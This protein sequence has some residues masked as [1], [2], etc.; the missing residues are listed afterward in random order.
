VLGY[1][2]IYIKNMENTR[3]LNDLIRQKESQ[4]SHLRELQQEITGNAA[5]DDSTN[6]RP[7][8]DS[9]VRG[10]E[11]T[12][13]EIKTEISN[14]QDEITNYK[15]SIAMDDASNRKIIQ[16]VSEII[17]YDDHEIDEIRKYHEMIEKQRKSLMG[18]GGKMRTLRRGAK[19]KTRRPRRKYYSIK[20]IK[21]RG[22]RI[23][24]RK[25]ITRCR[26]RKRKN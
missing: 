22:S 6:L 12:V 25:M 8:H 24:K 20:N 19:K 26:S 2:L 9:P 4:I 15:K 23:S 21:G 16:D 1:V 13:E 5:S 3:E 17:L 11:K 7:R 14:L 10:L 18:M